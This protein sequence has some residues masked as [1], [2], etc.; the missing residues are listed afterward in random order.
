MLVTLCHSRK[1]RKFCG[2][3]KAPDAAKLTIF[4][5]DFLPY[6][7]EAFEH[8]VKLTEPI[9]QK[10]GTELASSLV[11]GTTGIEPRTV[12]CVSISYFGCL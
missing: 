2:F 6:F 8:L 12:I 7:M 5:R 10:M 1:M 3:S 9:C 11:Y 4:K